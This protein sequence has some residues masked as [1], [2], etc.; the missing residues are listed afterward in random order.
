[1]HRISTP[2]PS[3][4]GRSRARR[5]VLVALA[6]NLA[7]AITKFAAFAVTRST[8]MLTEGI[9]SLVDTGDQLLLLV[10]QWRAA[11]PAD[12]THPFGYGLETYFWSFI[13]AL[14]IFFAGGTV[15]VW[16]GAEKLLH[17][18]PVS[19]PEISLTV[20]GASALFEGL[21]FR[22][23]YREYR[24]LAQGGD[25]RLFSF[26][27]IS[28]D[29][30]VFATL[31][32]DGAALTGLAI[33]A[34]GIIGASLLGRPWADGAASIA[35]GLLL[36]AIALFL[37]NETR[38]LIAGEAAAPPI[39]Q[40]IQA[41]I[42]QCVDLG[43]LVDLRTLHLGPQQILVAVRWRFTPGLSGDEL[44]AAAKEL[45]R[46]LRGADPRVAYVFFEC[47]DADGRPS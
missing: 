41:R 29:P 23:A 28:K 44:T 19:H 32:E 15:A 17:P 20:L 45:E 40:R 13:V 18:A 11:K 4:D 30:I 6:G 36:I 46:R 39:Q 21:S 43:S 12:A 3:I 27:R 34:L 22:T 9:H 24:R 1:M 35:I 8:A 38:S 42:A 7:I 14:M 33:A 5:V 47:V 37:A 16:E 10:G 25:V 26:L 31:L 2:P